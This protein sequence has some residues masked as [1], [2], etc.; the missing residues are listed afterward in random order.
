MLDRYEEKRRK[1]RLLVSIIS[2]L[3]LVTIVFTM[4]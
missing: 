1:Y 2:V 4:L 3:I